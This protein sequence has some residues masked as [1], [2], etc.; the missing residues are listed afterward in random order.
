[1]AERS[2]QM[3]LRFEKSFERAQ[4]RMELAEQRMA[5]AEQ[6][7]DRAEQRMD[8]FEKQI[9]AT[10]KLVEMGA[11][12]MIRLTARVDDLAKTQRA[13]LRSLGNGRNGN[14]HHGLRRRS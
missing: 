12:L 14:G 11:K 2:N 4:R 9:Q 3:E 6:R 7:M 5:R 10:R 13:F 8:K 1:M